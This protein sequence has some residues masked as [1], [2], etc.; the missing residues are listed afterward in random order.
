MMESFHLPDAQISNK[1]HDIEQSVR[2]APFTRVI[3]KP[4]F[5]CKV[6]PGLAC[7]ERLLAKQHGPGDLEDSDFEEE[8]PPSTGSAPIGSQRLEDSRCPIEHVPHPTLPGVVA[9]KLRWII[10]CQQWGFKTFKKYNIGFGVVKP[11][12]QRDPARR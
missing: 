6:G 1:G 10:R 7:Q 9:H 11:V 5:L 4:Q 8:F 3:T 12:P 2:R